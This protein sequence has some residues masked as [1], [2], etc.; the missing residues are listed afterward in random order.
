MEQN[1]R[2]N[3]TAATASTAKTAATMNVEKVNMNTGV[4]KI[5]EEGGNHLFRGPTRRSSPRERDKD[6]GI[7]HTG[8]RYKKK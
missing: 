8:G 1:S 2:R 3:Y 7:P 5:G 4:H 6:G